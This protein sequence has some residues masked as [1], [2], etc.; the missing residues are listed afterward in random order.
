MT[1]PRNTLV[2]AGRVFVTLRKSGHVSAGRMP[3]FHAV[4]PCCR[5]ALCATEPGA[6]SFW[7]EPPAPQV[8]CSH[9]LQR[10]TRL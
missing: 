2:R 5:M 1:L 9:C 8:T 3:V 10:P 6:G 7:A 4:T